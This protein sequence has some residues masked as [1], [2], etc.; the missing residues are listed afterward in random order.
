[1]VTVHLK[2]AALPEV[3]VA[4]GVV[5]LVLDKVAEPLLT[6][7]VP[8]YPEAGVLAESVNTLEQPN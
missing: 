5:E 6:D 3:M 1:M 8:V 4:V 7:P 2:L